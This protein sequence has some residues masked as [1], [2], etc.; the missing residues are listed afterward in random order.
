[1]EPFRPWIDFIV[2]HMADN[3]QLEVNKDSKQCLLGLLSQT[4]VYNKKKMPFMVSL[5]Y[6]ERQL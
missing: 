6:I 5:N 3:G 2:Y 1:M 4:V